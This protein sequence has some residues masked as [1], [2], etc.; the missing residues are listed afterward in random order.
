[1]LMVIGL[2]EYGWSGRVTS[3]CF[4]PIPKCRFTYQTE[5]SPQ[6]GGWQIYNASSESWS[7]PLLQF[8]SQYL[9]ISLCGGIKESCTSVVIVDV[10]IVFSTT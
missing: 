5:L 4:V 1:M 3:Q 6:Y 7:I 9:C 2:Y 10:A 8:I